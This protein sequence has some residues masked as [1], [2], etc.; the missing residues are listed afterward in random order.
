MNR[1]KYSRS[2]FARIGVR[3]G[4]AERAM[5]ETERRVIAVKPRKPPEQIRI[6]CT[7]QQRRQQCIFLRARRIDLVDFDRH[8]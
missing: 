3:G 2:T 6:G 8:R 7:R 5:R 4:L 1:S